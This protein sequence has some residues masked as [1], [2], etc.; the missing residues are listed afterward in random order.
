MQVANKMNTALEKLELSTL[1]EWCKNGP[2]HHLV[3][4]SSITKALRKLWDLRYFS[5][6]KETFLL[7]SLYPSSF[8]F[9]FTFYF[10]LISVG[11][12]ALPQR[13]IEM[14]PPTAQSQ[15]KHVQRGIPAHAIRCAS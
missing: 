2:K 6:A 4:T 12:Q 13:A 14:R 5:I 1:P 8:F 15:A 7:F 10:L 9:L 11:S 3:K